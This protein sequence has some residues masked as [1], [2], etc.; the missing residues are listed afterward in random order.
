MNSRRLEAQSAPSLGTNAAARLSADVASVGFGLISAVVTA[1]LLGPDGKGTLSTLLFLATLLSYASSLGLGDA[2]IIL[3]KR[4]EA[5]VQDAVPGIL[6]AGVAAAIVAWVVLGFVSVVADWESILPAVAIA[7]L[8]IPFMTLTRLLAGL[9][10]AVEAIRFTSLVFAFQSGVNAVGLVLFVALAKMEIT[11]GILASFIASVSAAIVLGRSLQRGGVFFRHPFQ[12]DFLAAAM[13]VGILIDISL[14]I[15]ALSQRLDL[16]IVYSLEGEAPA[17]RYSVALTLAQ[18]AAYGS[19]ALAVASFPRLA[20]VDPNQLSR[21]IEQ[22]SRVGLAATL[23]SAAF[24]ALVIPFA[25]RFLLGPE[26]VTA[27]TPALLLLAGTVVWS[28]QW[29]FARAAASR[30][31]GRLYLASLLTSLAVMVGL[32]FVLIPR[33]GINGAALASALSSVAGLTMALG[34]FR[35]RH[36]IDLRVALLWPRM[37]DLRLFVDFLRDAWR[38]MT[39]R[40]SPEL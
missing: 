9:K 40:P 20:G 15:A 39:R 17:G 4:R 3:I 23:L 32:D 36:A 22:I 14:I 11:G 13:R 10:N 1:R 29:L 37:A 19:V 35:K 34:G 18:L 7:G 5:V 33:F 12:R 31:D 28:Q 8:S 26:F 24:L 6:I 16:L 27:I 2:S 21:M 38:A 25:I 30:G